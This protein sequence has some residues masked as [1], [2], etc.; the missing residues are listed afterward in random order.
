M[1][2][3]MTPSEKMTDGQIDKAVDIFR[4]QLRKHRND[5]GSEAVQLVLGQSEFGID[6]LSVF[7][8]RVEAVSGMI[9]RHV[10]VDRTRSPGQVIDATG[11]VKYVNDKVV[12]TMP[13]GEGEETDVCFIKLNRWTSND[14]VVKEILDPLGL[15]PADP[16]SLAKVNEDDPA[17]ADEHPNG[18]QWKDANGNW[19]FATFYRSGGERNVYVC[20]SGLDWGGDWWV[21]GVCK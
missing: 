19:C 4:A 20:R 12:S 13:K 7:R 1:S 3:N 17:F 8:K 21:A 2:S 6:L 15:R 14:D 5:F 11:R 10:K 16:Y 9:V 18:C